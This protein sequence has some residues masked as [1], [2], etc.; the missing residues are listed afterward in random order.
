MKAGLRAVAAR[1][2][3]QQGVSAVAASGSLVAAV[4]P[5]E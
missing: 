5:L 3:A 2:I 1:L 4:S